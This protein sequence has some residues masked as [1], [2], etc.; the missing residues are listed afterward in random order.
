MDKTTPNFRNLLERI[1]LA[2]LNDWDP[3]GVSQ[4]PEAHDEYDAYGE[5]LLE[6]L[7]QK[8]TEDRIFAFLWELETGHI[9]LSET[10]ASR[11]HT[12]A[13]AHRI[14]LMSKEMPDSMGS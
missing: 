6:L 9:G 8:P 1:R 14:F 12:I 10:T 2:L 13:F 3:I 7:C 4:Y 11:E 5:P